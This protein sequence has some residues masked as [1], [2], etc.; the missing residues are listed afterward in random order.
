[1]TF[2]FAGETLCK[3]PANELVSWHQSLESRLTRLGFNKNAP[4]VMNATHSDMKLGN[5][6]AAATNLTDNDNVSGVTVPSSPSLLQSGSVIK[7]DT[8]QFDYWFRVKELRLFPPRRNNLIVAML[9]ASPD[10]HQLHDDIRSDIRAGAATANT[11]QAFS[12]M[13]DDSEKQVCLTHKVSLI[14]WI[15]ARINGH[16]TL[17]WPMYRER[18]ARGNWT[19]RASYS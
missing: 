18:A 17:P 14:C 10:W 1:M 19:L 9:E 15:I 13:S 16:H 11:H 6:T 8:M 7:N 3:L 2:F 4:P 5:E 12:T